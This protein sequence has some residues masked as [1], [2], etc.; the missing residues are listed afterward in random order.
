MCKVYTLQMMDEE[1]LKDYHGEG[2][3]KAMTAIELAAR[4]KEKY[5]QPGSSLT[6][7]ARWPW[8]RCMAALTCVLSRTWTAKPVWKAPKP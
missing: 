4:V 2:M 3:G 5:D 1:A 8:R 7:A 6:S